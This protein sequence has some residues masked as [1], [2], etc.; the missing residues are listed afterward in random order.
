MTYLE[1]SAW[2]VGAA[3]VAAI[4]LSVV[5]GRHRAHLGAV[6]VTVVVLFILTAVFL[7]LIHI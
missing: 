1:L 4:V 7:S 5:S 3:V 2:F 6:A